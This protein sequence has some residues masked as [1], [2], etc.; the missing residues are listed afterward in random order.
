MKKAGHIAAVA[1]LIMLFIASFVVLILVSARGGYD[2][3]TGTVLDHL[4]CHN[5]F[6]P[7]LVCLASLLGACALNRRTEVAG[8]FR[9]FSLVSWVFMAGMLYVVWHTLPAT[10]D[11]HGDGKEYILQ[12]QSI[13]LDGSI[14][15]DV[16]AARAYWNRTNPYGNTLNAAKKAGGRLTERA[17]AGGGFGGLYPDRFGDYRYYH[18]WMYSLVVAPL[19]ALFHLL[20]PGGTLEYQSFRI[21][22]ILF[23]CLPFALMW[24]RARTLPVLLL[25]AFACVTPLIGYTEWQH[26]ELFCFCMIMLAFWS[27]GLKR[28]AWSAPLWLGLGAS[29]NIP[30]A[31]FYIPLS[32]LHFLRHRSRGWH[33]FLKMTP[34]YGLGVLLAASSMFYY[35]YYFGVPN[36]IAAVGLADVSHA[37]WARVGHLFF[38]PLI[39]AC[40][41][42]PVCFLGTPSAVCRKSR[43]FIP[44]TVLSII[45]VS[46]L[47]VTT[48]NFNSSQ[49]WALRYTVWQ[50]A[51]LWFIVLNSEWQVSTIRL[52]GR[53]ALFVIEV[54]LIFLIVQFFWAWPLG[55]KDVR[56]F[57]GCGRSG[58]GVNALYALTPYP[59]DVEVLTENI[60][61]RELRHPD[62]FQGV[63]LWEVDKH[64]HVGVVSGHVGNRLYDLFGV[65][66]GQTRIRYTQAKHPEFGPYTRVYLRG[67]L[68]ALP[69]DLP[70]IIR[71]NTMDR[72]RITLR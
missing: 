42:F 26:P 56:G 62:Q 45:A 12:T 57:L 48:T 32:L 41:A 60:Q 30:I 3:S 24:I 49:I 43:V 63:Y 23:L 4:S 64:T 27:L 7:V 54:L 17:Q 31:L 52:N 18:F 71:T 36:V 61:T 50:L 9:R 10:A 15:V 55:E 66:S 47:C 67:A 72:R 40:W 59:E 29:Q 1:G 68:P 11:L 6:R 28:H 51:P 33:Y 65:A 22:N 34:A 19:Y 21:M 58:I 14:R 20:L 70:L 44:V 46:W 16:D 25:S 53:S 13:V 35:Q 69:G 8:L 5:L 2:I 37:S 39:G 38:S